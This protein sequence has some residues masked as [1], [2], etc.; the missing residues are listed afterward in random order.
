VNENGRTYPKVI[1]VPHF[2]P[3]IKFD[4]R[5][6]V[7]HL[8]TIR[9]PGD[10]FGDADPEPAPLLAYY[11]RAASWVL[12]IGRSSGVSKPIWTASCL[13]TSRPIEVSKV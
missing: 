9:M 8:S 3:E 4:R 6:S 12:G 11:Q 5:Q 10:A 1:F 7:P 2:I 13:D